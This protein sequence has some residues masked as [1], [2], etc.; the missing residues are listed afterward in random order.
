MTDERV[1]F[2]SATSQRS[3]IR[4]GSTGRFL[5]IF[6]QELEKTAIY[7]NERSEFEAPIPKATYYHQPLSADITEAL[8]VAPRVL[9]YLSHPPRADIL[10]DWTH[11]LY[12]L[13]RTRP[14]SFMRDTIRLD[15][16]SSFP[17]SRKHG[18]YPSSEF[19]YSESPSVL[20]SDLENTPPTRKKSAGDLHSASGLHLQRKG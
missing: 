7:M 3:T 11:G 18:S 17:L 4:A 5:L 1:T 6:P 10:I 13:P 14:P 16:R 20:A 15:S 8:G 9:V 12:Y 2:S 19:S